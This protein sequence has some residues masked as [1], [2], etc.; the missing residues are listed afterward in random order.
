MLMDF[1]V[2]KYRRNPNEKVYSLYSGVS[3]TGGTVT[4][5][6]KPSEDRNH[7]EATRTYGPMM[8]RGQGGQ[9]AVLILGGMETT[10]DEMEYI[11]EAKRQKKFVPQ[12]GPREISQMCQLLQ[13]RRNEAIKFFRRNPSEAPR[14]KKRIRLYLPVGYKMA[15]TREPGF[16]VRVRA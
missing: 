2:P 13:E 5:L 7:L 6:V 16:R 3:N 1:L 9:V 14:P 15:P 11:L 12:R 10:L 8:P 4:T